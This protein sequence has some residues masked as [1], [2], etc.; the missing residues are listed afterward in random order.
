LRLTGERGPVLAE[1][2]TLPP[3]EVPGVTITRAVPAHTLDRQT[4]KS[5]S[6]RQFRPGH[7]SLIH[8]ELVA[9]GEVLQGGPTMAAAEEREETKQVEQEGDHQARYCP[10]QS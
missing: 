2:A 8:G 3:E 7:R 9:Q 10:D 5:R 4:Q 6:L 1:A